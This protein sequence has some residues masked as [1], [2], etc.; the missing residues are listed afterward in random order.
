[1]SPDPIHVMKQRLVDPQQWNMYAYVRNNPLRFVDPTGMYVVNCKGLRKCEV[2]ADDFERN[3]QKDLNSKDKKVRDAAAAWGN[4]GEDNAIK[5]TFET[6]AQL[7]AENHGNATNGSVQVEKAADGQIHINATFSESLSGKDLQR[8]IAHEGSHI[9]DEV[10]FLT[11][12]DFGSGK[13]KAAFNM[14]HYDSEFQAF[15]TGATVKPYANLQCGGQT[16]SFGPGPKGYASLDRLLTT[17]PS[18]ASTSDQLLFDPAAY[19]QQ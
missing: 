19:P 12:F 14:F 8:T 18:Y 9:E 11:S 5:V 2:A 17:N 1:M 3:R 7:Q 10:R 6:A 4:R 13:F 16:C 15:E